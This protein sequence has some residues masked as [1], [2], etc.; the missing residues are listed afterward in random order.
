MAYTKSSF[1][2]SLVFLLVRNTSV[3]LSLWGTRP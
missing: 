2:E 3:S 1:H